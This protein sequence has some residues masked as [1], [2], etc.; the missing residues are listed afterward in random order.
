MFYKMFKH[1][2]KNNPAFLEKPD[3]FIV[4]VQKENSILLF[5]ES[6]TVALYLVPSAASEIRD[7][8]RS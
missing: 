7:F 8:N 4:F 5:C 6:V 3:W 2:P 1:E